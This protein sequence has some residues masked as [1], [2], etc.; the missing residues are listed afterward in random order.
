MNA[1]VARA[2]VLPRAGAASHTG[3]PYPGGIP[4]G[5][6]GLARPP[7]APYIRR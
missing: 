4:P 5:P 6:R 3:F 7:V 2:E 1:P